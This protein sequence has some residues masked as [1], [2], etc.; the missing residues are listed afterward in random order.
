MFILTN[1]KAGGE[2]RSFRRLVWRGRKMLGV[3]GGPGGNDSGG[4]GRKP[5]R[6]PLILLGVPI[7]GS[8]I[9]KK[10]LK[11]DKNKSAEP[12]ENPYAPPTQKIDLLS[13]NVSENLKESYTKFERSFYGSWENFVRDDSRKNGLQARRTVNGQEVLFVRQHQ[14]SDKIVSESV[15]WMRTASAVHNLGVSVKESQD[16]FDRLLRGMDMLIELGDADPANAGKQNGLPAFAVRI[17]SNAPRYDHVTQRALP[18][19]YQEALTAWQNKHPGELPVIELGYTENG[20]QEYLVLDAAADGS[21]NDAS[22][23]SH[24]LVMALL[25][26]VQNVRLGVWNGEGENYTNRLDGLIK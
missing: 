19:T 2:G 25:V 5:D 15:Y 26:A 21:G 6:L 22:D 10:L 16:V 14:L 11:E 24:D 20:I 3:L 9:T 4:R 1:Y 18:S 12:A 8:I 13:G 7:L 23:A 17:V